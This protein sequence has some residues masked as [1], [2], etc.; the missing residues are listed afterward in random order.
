MGQEQVDTQVCG[1]GGGL[2]RA[3][4]ADTFQL[5]RRRKTPACVL[6]IAHPAPPVRA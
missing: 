1:Q 3:A 4:P 2:Q 5:S 6:S